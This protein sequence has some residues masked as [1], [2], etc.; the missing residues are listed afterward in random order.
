MVKI[1]KLHQPNKHSGS[2]LEPGKTTVLNG[3]KITNKNNFVVF[4]DKFARKPWKPAAKQA[5]KKKAA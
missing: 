3:M 5:K 1:H 4:V 2:P